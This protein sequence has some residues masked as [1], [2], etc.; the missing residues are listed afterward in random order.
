MVVDRAVGLLILTE[1]QIWSSAVTT[2]SYGTASVPLMLPKA[3]P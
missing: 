2:S 1:C 3:A